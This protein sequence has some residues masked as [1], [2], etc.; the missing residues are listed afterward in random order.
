MIRDAAVNALVAMKDHSSAAVPA[1]MELVQDKDDAAAADY[2]HDVQAFGPGAKEA[3]SILLKMIGKSKGTYPDPVLTTIAAIGPDAKEA[4]PALIKLLDQKDAYSPLRSGAIDA[5]GG[6]G[7][8]SLPALDALLGVLAKGGDKYAISPVIRAIGAIGPKAEKAIPVLKKL[9]DHE[10]RPVRVWASFALTKITGESKYVGIMTDL[11][12]NDSSTKE[13]A[14]QV[15]FDAAQAFDQLGQ[16]GSSGRSVLI[17]AA[18]DLK[19]SLGTRRYVAS[20]LGKMK[21]EA[22]DIVP[23]L[24]S[25][26]EIK[27]DTYEHSDT[28]ENAIN[29]LANLG[30]LAKVAIP[31]L[32][33]LA[34]SDDD[35]TANAAVKALASIEKK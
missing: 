13:Y 25:V 21:A 16:A 19:T 4:V 33:K 31:S 32:R 23:K 12:D 34:D 5:L 14:N 29:A 20:A 6:I 1:I 17:K 24:I 10:S 35:A 7:P 11:W 26:A 15:A 8:E 22:D 28:R 18:T 9:L 3:M 2:L 27:G 30:P